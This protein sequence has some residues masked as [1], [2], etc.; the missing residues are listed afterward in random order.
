MTLLKMPTCTAATKYPMVMFFK[1]SFDLDFLF[2][3]W[4]YGIN[5]ADWD[6][7]LTP[8]EIEA[9]LNA[10]NF[11]NSNPNTISFQWCFMTNIQS[12]RTA[13]LGCGWPKKNFQQW[14]SVAVFKKEQ[15]SQRG[16][17]FNSDFI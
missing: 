11:V 2:A 13:M 16:L 3:D 4:E 7:V 9:R 8:P 15:R 17:S 12:I 10:F 5:V 1:N 14:G 6:V